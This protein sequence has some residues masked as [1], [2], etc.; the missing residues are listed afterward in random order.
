M[1]SEAI[2]KTV[3]RYYPDAQAI[4]LFGTYLTPDEHKD[5]DVDIALLLPHE[6][7]KLIKNLSVSEYRELDV[8]ILANVIE[9]RLDDLIDFTNQV[10]RYGRGS[11][12]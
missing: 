11:S 4:Y 9:R 8:K 10:M 3:L 12:S 7:A 5:S 1:N 2:V 6:K